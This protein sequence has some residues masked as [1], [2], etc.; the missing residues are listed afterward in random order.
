MSLTGEERVVIHGGGGRGRGGGMEGLWMCHDKV[1]LIS[2]KGY[3]IFFFPPPPPPSLAFHWQ[4]QFLLDTLLA[5]TD[6]SYFFLKTMRF[7]PLT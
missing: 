1:Y 3:V 7:L 4:S 6:P 2:L 5:M